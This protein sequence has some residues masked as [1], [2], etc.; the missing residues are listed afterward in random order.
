[1]TG[2]QAERV[3]WRQGMLVSPQHLQQLDAFHDDLLDARLNA[4]SPEC[5]GVRSL[6]LDQGAL[7]SGQLR[8]SQFSGVFADGLS[9]TFEA[10]EASAPP[11]RSIGDYLTSTTSVL[12]VFLSVRNRR[13]DVSSY[14]EAGDE[15]SAR[16]GVSEKLVTDAVNPDADVPVAVARPNA[17][18]LFGQENREG[19]QTIKFAEIVRDS[20]GSPELSRNFIPPCLRI[21]ASH[22]LSDQVRDLLGVMV[23]KQRSL[24]ETRRQRDASSV[25]FAARDVTRFLLLNTLNLH[26]PVLAHFARDRSVSPLALY[27]RLVELAGQLSTFSPDVDPSQLPAFVY[28]DLRTSF[29]D[30]LAEINRMLGTSVR[31]TCVPVP[32]EARQD[33][34]WI[35]RMKDER[36]RDCSVFVMAVESD[37]AEQRVANDLPPLSK[38]ASWKQIGK[39]VRSAVAGVRIVATH[40]PPP[41]VPIRPRRV[42][43]LLQVDD[44]HWK[45]IAADRNIAIYLPPPYDPAH[46]KVTLVGVPELPA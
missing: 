30:L 39:I 15:N 27:L 10:G 28:T 9:V 41:E 26:I 37:A 35:G 20:S 17:V 12:E 24:S 29:D 46:A 6:A 42:Y 31:D 13:N 43:F 36:L 18:I 40:R 32:L 23:V 21:S 45:H 16:F 3:V 34:M 1:M 22:F 33:G 2:K 11:T 5:W 25:E 19:Y 14:G 44:P 38:I 8:V 7:R 4:L